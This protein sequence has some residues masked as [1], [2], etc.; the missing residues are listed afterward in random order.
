MGSAG[1]SKGVNGTASKDQ[2]I[3]YDYLVER[4]AQFVISSSLLESWESH[5]RL[6]V[7]FDL[8]LAPID[9][10][11]VLSSETWTKPCTQRCERP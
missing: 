11:E 2:M 5:S 4:T 8:E 6:I 9:S 1:G 3:L 7:K 10:I